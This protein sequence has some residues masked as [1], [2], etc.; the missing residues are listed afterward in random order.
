[1]L[2]RHGGGVGRMRGS[3]AAGGGTTDRF[4]HSGQRVCSCVLPKFGLRC[5]LGL[6]ET[7]LD[8]GEVAIALTRPEG[9]L[10]ARIRRDGESRGRR[11]S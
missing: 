2:K 5:T 3:G 6:G 7:D 4:V 10:R 1:M 9:L 11:E 8:S